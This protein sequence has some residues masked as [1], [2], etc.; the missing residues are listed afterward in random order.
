MLGGLAAALLPLAQ[1]WAAQDAADA[2]SQFCDALLKVM[3]AGQAGAPFAQRTAMLTPAIDR[4]FDLDT[5]LRVSIGPQWSSLPAD[6]QA[7]LRDAF[8]RYTLAN[9]A[10][11]FDSF[12]GET[13]QVNPEPRVLP[14]GDEIVTTTIG[15]PGDSPTTLAY[16]MRQ[17]PAGWQAVDVLANGNISRVA[18]QR[19]DFRSLLQSGGAPALVSSLESKAAGLAG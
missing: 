10:A 1:A 7:A 19:S 5:I 13:I 6:Q 9:F 4:A 12:D 8:R 11:N 2:V 17:G 14:N 3:R 18:T 15:K 16:V